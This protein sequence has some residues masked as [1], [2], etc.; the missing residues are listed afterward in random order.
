MRIVFIGAGEIGVPTLQ[1]LPK[2]EH[3]VVGVVTQPD[4][5]VGRAQKIEPPPIKKAMAGSKMPPILQPT[6]IKEREAGKKLRKALD[7]RAEAGEQGSARA[8]PVEL[9]RVWNSL[10][11]RELRD[12][13]TQ[14]EEEKLR[15]HLAACMT[16]ETTPAVWHATLNALAALR[17]AS[18]PA[19]GAPRRWR[20]T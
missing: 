1:A 20:Q 19:V 5:P 13:L 3:E 14:P 2:S 10:A 9:A 15:A 16:G 17:C 7:R 11:F 12:S 8:N 6:R 4:K 18:E